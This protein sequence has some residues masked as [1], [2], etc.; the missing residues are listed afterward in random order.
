MSTNSA[1]Q[2]PS[3]IVYVV[4]DT[5]SNS[6]F[7]EITDG[8]DVEMTGCYS[9]YVEVLSQQ[10]CDNPDKIVICKKE[11]HAYFLQRYGYGPEIIVFDRK[12]FGG[13]NVL[14]DVLIL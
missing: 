10:V 9:F 4:H 3:G 13:T 11:I 12:V 7:K 8:F 14:F 6:F 5:D 1:F 2:S